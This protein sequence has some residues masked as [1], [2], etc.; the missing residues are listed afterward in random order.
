MSCRISVTSDQCRNPRRRVEPPASGLMRG[1]CDPG[2]VH[3]QSRSVAVW[4]IGDD[5]LS[6][7]GSR[8]GSE[9]RTRWKGVGTRRR[10]SVAGRHDRMVY[11][12]NQL[13]M[14][15]GAEQLSQ[16]R[17]IGRGLRGQIVSPSAPGCNAAKS[18]PPLG[19]GL[20]RYAARCVEAPDGSV[21]KKSAK[22]ESTQFSL[23][24]CNS[25]LIRR[26][27]VWVVF[28]IIFPAKGRQRIRS[29]VLRI[30][31]A[32]GPSVHIVDLQPRVA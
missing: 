20:A 13:P 32:H 16:P 24:V 28:G 31:L 7:A 23:V 25:K 6:V 15:A 14:L 19:R 2:H 26:V 3:R 12:W 22:I 17:L 27:P 9:R 4:D 1:T 8:G 30:Q 21:L 11:V 18:L 29:R 5:R 10:A